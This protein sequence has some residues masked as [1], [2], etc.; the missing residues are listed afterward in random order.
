MVT[1][2]HT[3]TLIDYENLEL[4]DANPMGLLSGSN[5]FLKPSER[6]Y[7]DS[8]NPSTTTSTAVNERK[9]LTFAGIHT[10]G[11]KDFLLRPELMKAIED[12]GFEHPSEVQ[13]QCIP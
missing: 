1:L 3:E 7:L 4:D 12:C 6:S 8:A 11:F 2:N 9:T 10:T 13:Q 5:T